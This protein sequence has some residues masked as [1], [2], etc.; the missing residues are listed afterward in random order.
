M[1]KKVVLLLVG[2]II[3]NSAASIELNAS[4]ST[5]VAPLSVH[6]TAGF[7]D[8]S[9]TERGF[10][11]YDYSWDFDDSLSGNWGTIGKSKNE[12]KGPVA[13]HVFES[14]GS[15]TVTLTVRDGSGVIDTRTFEIIVTDP[16]IVYSGTTTCVSSTA[17]F[18]GCPTGANQVTTDDLTTITGYADAGERLLFNRGSSWNSGA[19]DFPNNAGPVSIGAYGTCSSPDSLGICSN[20]PHITVT[21][22]WFI[23]FN[24]KQDWRIS[25]LYFT[26]SGASAI[27]GLIDVQKILMLRLKVTGFGV[28]VG[29]GHWKNYPDDLI[30]Q[31]ML[32]ENDI[33]GGA[34]NCV[35]IGSERIAIMGNKIYDADD[36]H[37]LRVWQS[38]LGVISHNIISGASIN[39]V[40]GRHALKL[41]GPPESGI[42]GG[43]WR[44][45]IT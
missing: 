15:Y 23:N 18:V 3:V 2:L 40:S 27:D 21:G 35:Y 9:P 25:D 42:G 34:T 37:V 38:Y 29:N 31:I 30:D 45:S 26:G 8:S 41:H 36:S 7:T 16:D 13:A 5:G 22:N 1:M 17:D 6:F 24:N 44:R 43:Y 20:A 14:S 11:N 12:A 33:S 28:P 39:S 19:L 4:R 10:H 32:V